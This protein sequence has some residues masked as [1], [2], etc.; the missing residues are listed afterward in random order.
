MKPNEFVDALDDERIVAAIREAEQRTRAEIRVHVTARTVEDAKQAAASAFSK[1]GMAGTDERNGVLIFLAPK[2]R[3]FAVLGDTG[4]HERC[5]DEFWSRV[6]SA[7]SLHFREGRFSEGLVVGIAAAGSELARH[8]PRHAGDG[9]R[10]ELPD[11][12]SRDD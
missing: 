5:G 10:N 3:S 4:I 8:F 11:T 1:L 6:A 2:S 7:M 9:D 12:V